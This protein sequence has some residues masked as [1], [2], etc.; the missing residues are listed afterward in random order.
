MQ[1]FAAEVIVCSIW[2]QAYGSDHQAVGSKFDS[3][4]TRVE[5]EPRL[6]FK[7][8]NWEGSN[9]SVQ[10]GTKWL[11]PPSNIEEFH[12]AL[13]FSVDGAVRTHTPLA[14]PSPYMKQ[15]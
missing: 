6:V 11:P 4:V 3:L 5:P 10:E 8:A 12:N 2:D 7:H 9:R 14:E 15:W 13:I 1:R